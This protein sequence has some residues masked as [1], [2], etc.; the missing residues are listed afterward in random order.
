MILVVAGL[1]GWLVLR[2]GD[3]WVCL[4]WNWFP[5]WVFVL[6][7]VVW[8]LIGCL[9]VCFVCVF[10]VCVGLWLLFWVLRVVYLFALPICGFVLLDGGFFEWVLPLGWFDCWL[11][12]LFSCRLILYVF[13]LVCGNGVMR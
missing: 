13:C 1:D 8:L 6:A 12:V 7:Q 10:C 2:I 4:V 11:M 9:L 5:G 3:W